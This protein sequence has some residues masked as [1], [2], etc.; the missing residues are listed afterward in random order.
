MNGVE[1]VRVWSRKADNDLRNIANN[2]RGATDDSEIPW[3]TL[4]FHAQQAAENR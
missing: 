2:L 3:D 1:D 4:C